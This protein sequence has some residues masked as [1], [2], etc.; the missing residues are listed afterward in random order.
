MFITIFRNEEIE[1]KCISE[2]YNIV[3]Q[4]STLKLALG[5]R[6]NKTSENKIIIRTCFSFLLFQKDIYFGNIIASFDTPFS[7][8]KL[9]RRTNKSGFRKN[10]LKSLKVAK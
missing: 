3:S 9:F 5:R 8:V 2:M 1:V 6:G 4:H 10:K 7:C